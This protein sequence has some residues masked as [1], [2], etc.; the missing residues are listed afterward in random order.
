MF[1]AK[2]FKLGNS[3][4]IYIPKEVYTSLEENKEYEW[5]V[6]TSEQEKKENVYTSK[7][8]K[9]GHIISPKYN[10]DLKIGTY[11]RIKNTTKPI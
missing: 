9:P 2:L 5:N 8:S 4:A 3:R 1:K 10:F 6:Y 7:P 11:K